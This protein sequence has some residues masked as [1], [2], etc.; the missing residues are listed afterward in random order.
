MTINFGDGTTIAS[1]GSLGKVLQTL[2]TAKLNKSSFSI[3]N[4]GTSSNIVTVSI[5]PSST[6]NKI[7]IFATLTASKDDT[8]IFLKLFRDSTQIGLGNASGQRQ[9]FSTHAAVTQNFLSGS[10]T[11]VMLDEPSTTSSITYAI[12]AG[13]GHPSTQTIAVNAPVSDGTNATQ[14]GRGA[15]FITVQEVAG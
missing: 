15:S 10:T 6:S 1:G 8:G 11:C 12:R 14:V 4:G 2:S 3:S 13:H 9:R 5:T 7:L